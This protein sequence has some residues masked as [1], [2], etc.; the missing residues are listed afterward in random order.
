M[1]CQLHGPSPNSCIS[2][3]CSGNSRQTNQNQRGCWPLHHTLS[4]CLNSRG[5]GTTSKKAWKRQVEKSS[6]S[7]FVQEPCCGCGCQFASKTLRFF[8]FASQLETAVVRSLLS[9]EDCD[10]RWC[11]HTWLGAVHSV[12]VC[13]QVLLGLTWCFSSFT[14]AFV[15]YAA[16]TIGTAFSH[17]PGNS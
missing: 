2:A 13:S 17:V 15:T 5:F 10:T 14:A 8:A 12:T 11:L 7:R 3:I 9:E 1:V 4:G 6:A 16:S